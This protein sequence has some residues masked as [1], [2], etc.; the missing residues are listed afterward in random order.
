MPAQLELASLVDSPALVALRLKVSENLTLRYGKG[1]WSGKVTERGVLFE[2]RKSKVYVMRDVSRV[3]AT[4]TLGTRKPWAID[5][6][7]FSPCRRPIYLTAMAV[8]P[9]TQRQGVGRLC[10]AG[11][12]DAAKRMT[13]DAIWL[14]AYDAEAGA[15]EFYRKCGFREVGRAVYRDVPLIYFEMRL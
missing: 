10:M 12:V 8:A 5:P 14:D 7:Y 6:K 4:V 3:I 11:A 9:E 2:M 13:G 15:G 1:S